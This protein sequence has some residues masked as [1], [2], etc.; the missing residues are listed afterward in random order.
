MRSILT[1]LH[2]DV[3]ADDLNGLIGFDTSPVTIVPAEDGYATTTVIERP[4]V[5]TPEVE[6]DPD[7]PRHVTTWPDWTPVHGYSGAHMSG[8]SA[9]MHPSEFIGGRM[10]EDLIADGGTHTVAVVEDPDDVDGEPVGW[11]LLRL[12]D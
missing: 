9:V 7:D 5:L 4:D 3:A 12:E 10:A 1:T 8:A 2:T 6:F 11:T